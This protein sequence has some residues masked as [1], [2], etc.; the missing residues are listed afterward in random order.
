MNWFLVKV[1][2]YYEMSYDIP[3]YCVQRCRPPQ[4]KVGFT[5]TQSFQNIVHATGGSS[6][7]YIR[8]PHPRLQTLSNIGY[9]MILAD[10]RHSLPFLSYYL[11]PRFWKRPRTNL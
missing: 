8:H 5:S 10:G 1:L 7:I 9:P 4:P 11:F 3:T 6:V 2:G